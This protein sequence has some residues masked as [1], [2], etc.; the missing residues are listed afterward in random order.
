[1]RFRVKGGYWINLHMGRRSPKSAL[2]LRI[3][4]D[5]RYEYTAIG[6]VANM[7]ARLCAEAADR[8]ILI[9]E[10]VQGML[11]DLVETEQLGLLTLKGFQHPIPALNVTAI[12]GDLSVSVS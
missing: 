3:G 9:S 2:W 8:Q 6:S 4:F 11:E 5:E 7:A 1:M 10:L 12:R